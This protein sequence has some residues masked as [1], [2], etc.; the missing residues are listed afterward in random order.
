MAKPFRRFL[1]AAGIWCESFASIRPKTV[2]NMPVNHHD[3]SPRL[4]VIASA[5]ILQKV[6]DADLN[7]G[8]VYEVKV[9]CRK[10]RDPRLYD[11]TLDSPPSGP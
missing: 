4:F 11:Y 3:G 6:Y 8:Y 2:K 1:R 5:Q 9:L 10:V 7:R